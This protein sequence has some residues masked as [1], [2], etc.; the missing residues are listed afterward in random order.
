MSKA[1]SGSSPA[2]KSKNPFMFAERLKNHGYAQFFGFKA[3]ISSYTLWTAKQVNDL[4]MLIVDPGEGSEGPA[5]PLKTLG[6]RL[7]F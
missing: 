2:G 5:R 1:K 3:P 7:I 6:C 4:Q